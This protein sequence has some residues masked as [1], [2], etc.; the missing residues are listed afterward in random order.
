MLGP[1]GLIRSAALALVLLAL[2]VA[3]PASARTDLVGPPCLYPAAD[4]TSAD[5]ATAAAV[6]APTLAVVSGAVSSADV[7]PT[8][9]APLSVSARALATPI[10]A[11]CTPSSSWDASPTFSGT[12]YPDNATADRDE[13]PFPPPPTTTLPTWWSNYDWDQ[14]HGSAGWHSAGSATHGGTYGIQSALLGHY[15]LWLWPSGGTYGNGDYAEWTYTAPGTTRISTAQLWFL[16][17]NKLLSHHCLEV[18]LRTA[19]GAIVDQTVHCK[20]TWRPDFQRG[21]G[22]FLVDPANS[23]SATVLYF[24]IRLD[25]GKLTTCTKTIPARNP[26]WNGSFARLLEA[27]VKLVDDDQPVV[28]PS[29][30]LWDLANHYSAGSSVVGLTVGAA[31]AGSGIVRNWVERAGSDIGKPPP[32]P[33]RTPCIPPAGP[34]SLDGSSGGACP[35][36]P[37][38]PG[39]LAAANAPCDPTHHTAALD[40]RTCPPAF[41]FDASIDLKPFPEGPNLFTA[42]SLDPAGN[43]GTRSWTVFVDRTA[44][45]S[46]DASGSLYDLAGQTSDGSDQEGLT[47]TAHDPGADVQKAAGIARVW[48]EEVGVGT[49]DSSDNPD[50]TQFV[51]PDTYSADFSVDL[52]G[53]SDGQHTFVVKATDLVGNVAEGPTWTITIAGAGDQVAPDESDT[54]PDSAATPDAPGGG[55]DA[56]DPA[57]D[58][59]SACNAYVDVG[60]PDWCSGGSDSTGGTASAV[61]PAAAVSAAVVNPPTSYA[62]CGLKAVFWSVGYPKSLTEQLA[63]YNVGDACG[64]YYIAEEPGQKKDDPLCLPGLRQAWPSNLHAA[65]VFQWSA[66]A[67]YVKD[68][69]TW[70][71]AGV[72]FRNRMDQSGCLAGDRWF[73]NELPSAWHSPNYSKQTN[74]AVRA[75]IANAL[76]GLF[77][78]G[79]QTDIQ[80]FTADV[81]IAHNKTD[82]GLEYKPGLKTAYAADDFW[83]AVGK[84]VQG[85]GKEVYNRCSQICVK[86]KTAAQIADGGVN[87][88]SYHESFLAAAA[89][90]TSVYGPVKTTLRAH[91][92]PLLNALWNNSMP[93]YDSQLLV[94]QMARVIRQQIYSARRI[95]ATQV[96]A[97]GRIGFAWTENDSTTAGAAAATQLAANLAIAVRNAYRTGGT[98]AAACVDNDGGD[99]VFYGCPPA[100]RPAAAFN[101]AWNIFKNW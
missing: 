42:G 15:G 88:Y 36:G 40:S 1:A 69:H 25:C 68:G 84:Y 9:I 16:Y 86:A 53:L 83:R 73:V 33:A 85:F 62:G 79:S 20:P 32:L 43:V 100:G 22:A 65:P 38:A 24:R 87:N 70:Y 34:A 58:P 49:V 50:C 95:A 39:L 81:V 47:V 71:Q 61:A 56:Y 77:Q 97:A 101:P 82:M 72:E 13:R 5:L 98:A 76:R 96:G 63:R 23:P 67:Q 52:S 27:H 29:G 41:S 4:P 28:T 66:W 26:Y 51:C 37:V 74:M 57:S 30:G 12:Y 45:D 21:G 55:A 92:F 17:R 91:H 75:R 59:D 6:G 93:V 48:L 8:A 3:P 60:V 11:L 78:G 19:S 35:P 89:P 80:G 46:V 10:G 90:S 7:S 64:D 31:D 44:P 99:T 54:P 2:G 14:G 94:P 18:G